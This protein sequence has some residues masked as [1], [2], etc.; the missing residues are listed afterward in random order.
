MLKIISI[1]ILWRNLVIKMKQDC[2]FVPQTTKKL[3]HRSSPTIVLQCKKKFKYCKY[4]VPTIYWKAYSIFYQAFQY[5]H[6]LKHINPVFLELLK[7]LR[8][9]ASSIFFLDFLD[10]QTSFSCLAQEFKQ[11][12]TSHATLQPTQIIIYGFFHPKKPYCADYKE[13]PGQFAHN[14]THR[15]KKKS[16]QMMRPYSKGLLMYKKNMKVTAF[17]CFLIYWFCSFSSTVL[18]EKPSILPWTMH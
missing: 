12:L 14:S 10:G 11:H 16:R 1:T 8:Q 4:S 6:S 7:V 17:F 2:H 9:Q 18:L 13:L 5:Q 15:E 3:R